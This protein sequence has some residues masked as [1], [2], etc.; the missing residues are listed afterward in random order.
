MMRRCP[1]GWPSAARAPCRASGPRCAR[2]SRVRRRGR[3]RGYPRRR[4][5]T[6]TRGAV[7]P[8]GHR[9]REQPLHRRRVMVRQVL[10][11][12]ARCDGPRPGEGE[13]R[14]RVRVVERGDLGHHATDADT[15]QVRRPVVEFAGQCCGVG[16]E[17]A[18]R[19]RGCLG[20]D[21][22]RRAAVAQVVPHDV[23]LPRASASQSASGQESIVVP[24]AS[25]ISGAV[26]SPNCSTPCVTPLASTVVI[27]AGAGGMVPSGVRSGRT[28]GCIVDLQDCGIASKDRPNASNSSLVRHDRSSAA[29]RREDILVGRH[30]DVRRSCPRLAPRPTTDHLT[31][32][33]LSVRPTQQRRGRACRQSRRRR[34]SMRSRSPPSAAGFPRLPP[35]GQR[36]VWPVSLWRAVRPGRCRAGP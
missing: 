6:L 16:C 26:A 2:R 18:Q 27:E 36:G 25:K 21:D 10:V 29:A 30:T 22:G 35:P 23:T 12:P 8:V 28:V 14:E 33:W 13:R 19:V 9:A 4:W 24:P 31:G 5:R 11:D 1:A 3:R 15:R 20:I 32:F 34:R 17:I 7:G